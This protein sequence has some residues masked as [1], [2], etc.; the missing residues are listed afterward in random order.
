MDLREGQLE[1]FAVVADACA[2]ALVNLPSEKVVADVRAVAEALG[3]D[4]FEGIE[5]T[6]ELEQRY[7]DRFFV[8][9]H[10]AYV[11]LCE[12]SVRG[13]YEDGG[14]FRYGPT[15]GRFFEHVLK[16]YQT[17]GFDYR[18]I[19][20]F[21]LAKGKLMPDSLASELAFLAFLARSAI[22]LEVEDPAAARRGVELLEAF[23]RDHAGRWFDAAAERLACFEDDFYAK[24]ASLAAEAVAAVKASEA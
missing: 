13:G 4:W 16:C 17:V 12:D 15:N 7:Y 2:E 24:V 14:R 11:P 18:L 21:D 5:A 8:S 9:S 20:G 3:L 10:P 6:P 19:K 1:G 23:A 22:Q